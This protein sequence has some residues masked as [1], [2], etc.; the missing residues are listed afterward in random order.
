[1]N[2]VASHES[3]LSGAGINNVLYDARNLDRNFLPLKGSLVIIPLTH[4]PSFRKN[5]GRKPTDLINFYVPSVMTEHFGSYGGGKYVK[6][7]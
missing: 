1:M 2:D 4:P 7:D 5:D 3:S 6:E